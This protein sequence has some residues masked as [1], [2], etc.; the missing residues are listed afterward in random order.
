MSN[1]A[2]VNITTQDSM[3]IDAF[4][5]WRVSAPHTIFDSK[6]IFDTQPLLWDDQEISGGSTTSTYSQP[7]ARTQMLVAASTAGNRTRQTFMRFNYQPGKSQFVLM[8]SRLSS[9]GA[10]ISSS[11]GLFDDNDGIFFRVLNGVLYAVIRSGVTGSP[12][13]TPVAQSSFN[14]DKLDGTGASGIDL[15]MTKAQIM[16]F[17]YE[18][19][20][21]GRVRMGFVVDGALVIAHEFSHA[22]SVESVYMSTPNLPL[23]YELINDG[24]GAQTTLDHICSSVMSEGDLEPIGKLQYIS[25]A[26]TPVVCTSASVIYAIVGIRLKAAALGATIDILDMALQVQSASDSGEWTLRISPSVASA[27]TYSDVTNS[28]LQRA[29]GA[30][31]NTVTGGTIVGGGFLASDAAAS[32]GKGGFST[33]LENAIRLGSAI[34]GTPQTL[35]LCFMPNAATTAVSVEGAITIREL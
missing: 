8:T 7:Y 2:N 15:D 18:W 29:L 28:A 32:G 6:Q 14:K 20:G 4:G 26:G 3:A 24:T 22:N 17:D 16:F 11:V 21:V 33:N 10:G 23:R 25:T 5:R 1:F 35:V 9:L 19:L 31:A 27:F 12:V 13:D 34:D 30:S